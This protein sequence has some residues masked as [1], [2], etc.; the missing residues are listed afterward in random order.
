VPS[1]ALIL[2]PTSFILRI[3]SKKDNEV[4]Q[5]EFIK[6]QILH[7]IN[8]AAEY[9]KDASSDDEEALLLAGIMP[10]SRLAIINRGY[11]EKA[12]RTLVKQNYVRET[13]LYLIPNPKRRTRPIVTRYDIQKPRPAHQAR[14][15][16]YRVRGRDR[17]LLWYAGANTDLSGSRGEAYGLWRVLTFLRT[18]K[19]QRLWRQFIER[20]TWRLPEDAK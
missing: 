8:R 4:E 10:K 2:A 17:L 11:P 13:A 7:V 5:L 6:P 16:T 12:V 14:P 15:I 9:S 19:V 20:P 18:K 3:P 1:S